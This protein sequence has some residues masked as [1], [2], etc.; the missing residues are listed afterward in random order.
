M[1]ILPATRAGASPRHARGSRAISW[2]DLIDGAAAVALNPPVSATWP[3]AAFTCSTPAMV[4]SVAESN[5]EPA[6]AA[7]RTVTSS[8]RLAESPGALRA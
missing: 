1:G 5:A 8:S 3:H 7:G 2:S 6:C 4:P